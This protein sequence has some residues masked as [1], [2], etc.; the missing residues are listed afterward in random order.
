MSGETSEGV[1]FDEQTIT[2]TA[3]CPGCGDPIPVMA[4]VSL[5]VCGCGL[6]Q[7]IVTTPDLTDMAAHL[8]THDPDGGVDES[9]R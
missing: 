6:H 4:T 5:I 1:V 7:T 8:F 3:M 9:A 2:L